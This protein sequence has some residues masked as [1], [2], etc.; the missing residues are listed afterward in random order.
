[1]TDE[2]APAAPI[3][4]RPRRA[5]KDCAASDK[6]VVNPGEML[7]TKKGFGRGIAK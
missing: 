3:P 5:S 2:R 4:K 1:M 6:I 7:V